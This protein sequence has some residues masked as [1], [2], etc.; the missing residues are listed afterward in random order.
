[1]NHT[2]QGKAGFE[3]RTGTVETGTQDAIRIAVVDDLPSLQRQ[4]RVA[5][6]AGDADE[7]ARTRAVAAQRLPGRHLPHRGDA[8]R[9]RPAGGVATDQS[10]AALQRQFAQAGGE[11]AHPG[12][13]R[14]GQGQGE[15]EPARR[16][17]HRGHVGEIYRQS[18]PAD[19]GGLGVEREVTASDQRVGGHH[20]L[21]AG[22]YAQQSGVVADSERD[23]IGRR[24]EFREMTANQLEFAH[25]GATLARL[26]TAAPDA[27]ACRARR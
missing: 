12:F 18:L 25:L 5:E 19:V 24:R 14:L 21:V 4:S 26:P 22:C 16:S 20:Q 23:V 7:V 11:A 1:M 8:D 3:A 17:A 27:P 15:R 9:E 13:V 6:R 10:R 2:A